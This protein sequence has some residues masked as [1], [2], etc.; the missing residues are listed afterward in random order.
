MNN[1]WPSTR[2]QK[3][4]GR[5]TSNVTDSTKARRVRTPI[6]VTIQQ[7][8][9][10]QRRKQSSMQ[11]YL[12]YKMTVHPLALYCIGVVKSANFSKHVLRIF[13]ILRLILELGWPSALRAD[14]YVSA[15]HRTRVFLIPVNQHRWSACEQRILRPALLRYCYV[16]HSIIRNQSFWEELVLKPT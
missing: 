10:K 3:I 7:W 2:T 11:S 15:D 14:M 12:R 4:A 9:N 6:A 8:F 16:K 13:S 1:G 5:L